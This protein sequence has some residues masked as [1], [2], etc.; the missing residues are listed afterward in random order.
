MSI[1]YLIYNYSMAP[2]NEIN[3]LVQDFAADLAGALP[4]PAAWGVWP[5]LLLEELERQAAESGQPV[6]RFNQTLVLI[7]KAAGDRLDN[8]ER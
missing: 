3:E 8:H 2:S 4:D 1:A 5:N 6:E 7:E